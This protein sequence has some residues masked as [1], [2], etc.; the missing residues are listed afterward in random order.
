MKPEGTLAD[1]EVF[2]LRP[3]WGE[4]Q[5]LRSALEILVGLGIVPV[6]LLLVMG[7]VSGAPGWAYPFLVALGMLGAAALAWMQWR[8]EPGRLVREGDD[9]VLENVLGAPLS[10]LSGAE[11]RRLILYWVRRDQTSLP[12]RFAS[13]SRAHAK[14]NPVWARVVLQTCLKLTTV[15]DAGA[16][17]EITV[18]EE[19]LQVLETLAFEA[20]GPRMV[21]A[22]EWLGYRT[23]A[24][25]IVE[26][27]AQRPDDA[28]LETKVD[29]H[30]AADA[31][32]AAF[33]IKR[34]NLRGGGGSFLRG[35]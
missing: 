4:P 20:L 6:G 29:L 2:A 33:T 26:T 11:Q 28:L 10:R 18:S 17:G 15:V 19:R 7:G 32:P 14:D 27:A 13:R 16:D 35:S 8:R 31:E 9:L 34:P 1:L 22:L 5:F 24:R 3:V 21:E 30:A 23:L 12:A 25:T